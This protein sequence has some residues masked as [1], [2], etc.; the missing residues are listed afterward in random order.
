TLPIRIQLHAGETL[1]ELI[2]RVHRDLLDLRRLEHT[3]L[4]DVARCSGVPAGRALFDSVLVI[5]N[6][7]ELGCDEGKLRFRNFD[8]MD[9]SD[10]ALSI[11]VMPGA[12]SKLLALYDPARFEPAAM[13]RLLDQFAYALEHV[14]D[15]L[16]SP[17]TDLPV[18]PAKE[19]QLLL[20]WGLGPELLGVQQATVLDQI[21]VQVRQNPKQ[22]ALIVE[23]GRLSYGELW[24]RSQRYA[25]A[26]VTR[27][28]RP[29]DRVA[30]VLER[31]GEYV[32]A[33]LGVLRAGACYVPLDPSYPVQRIQAML[34]DCKPAQI[35]AEEPQ[36]QRLGLEQERVLPPAT[37]SLAHSGPEAVPL[38]ELQGQDLAYL[39][40]TSG[41]TG[42]PKAVMVSH[43]NLLAS[44]MAREQFYAE[45][46]DLFLLL[47][48]FAFDSSVAGIYWPLTCGGALLVSPMA[49]EQD[50]LALANLIERYKVSHTLCLPALAELLIELAPA[51]K[52]KS[53]RTLVVA[54]EAVGWQLPERVRNTLPLLRV[55]NEYGPTE[56]TVWCTM[57]D[58]T[59][60]PKGVAPAIG[61][62]IPGAVLRVLDPQ[63]RPVPIGADGELW[64]GG[65]GVAAGYFAQPDISARSFQTLDHSQTRFYRTGDLVRYSEH[66]A[67]LFKGRQDSQI[68]LRGH[69]IELNEIE[70]VL[71]SH[72]AVQEAAALLSPAGQ[73]KPPQLLAFLVPA[74]GIS[75]TDQ[76]ILEHCREQ[77]PRHMVPARIGLCEH[78]PR[79]PNGKVDRKALSLLQP[80]ERPGAGGDRE[81]GTR[82]ERAMAD[83]WQRVLAVE[84]VG[85]DDDFFALGG[86]SLKSI[87]IVALAR[88]RE[89]NLAP[90]EIF[91]YPTIRE[92]AA[93]R[94]HRATTS[95]QPEA[96]VLEHSL[97][98]ATLCLVHGGHRVATQLQ[99]LLGDGRSVRLLSDHRDAG[100]LLPGATV[101]SMAREYL[102]QINAVQTNP[103]SVLAGYS[104]G[105][106]VAFEMARLWQ[107]QGASVPLLLLLDPPDEARYMRSAAGFAGARIKTEAHR[108]DPRQQGNASVG[109][110]RRT[111]RQLLG[112]L[113]S[114]LRLPMP[115]S[116]RH[117]YVGWVYHRA[118]RRYEAT[119]CEG[120][121]AI[122]Y[123]GRGVAR[124]SA[125][126]MLWETLLDAEV[127]SYEF[128]ASHTE[129]VRRPETISA[130]TRHLKALLSDREDKNRK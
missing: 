77:L 103:P 60:A 130:W 110:V 99:E 78:L 44:T 86:D 83:I 1:G 112:A 56:A 89:L 57:A 102:A 119:P 85:L 51:Q 64:V 126:R 36:I 25:E 124:D 65:T 91:E 98:G 118:L 117:S 116:V 104:I 4:G 95:R 30:I 35:I 10:F 49:L 72:E 114:W 52:L 74:A 17:A 100:A 55:C 122:I 14:S 3:P 6:H 26:L 38:P 115:L 42:K 113:C 47:S 97:A 2:E 20:Q 32:L 96:A 121:P 109:R 68:K 94:E 27:Q 105:A 106:P 18:L 63:Q 107:K 53:L 41:S 80:M 54:G 15:G 50:M 16:Q 33:M 120:V 62:P 43:E 70:A 128:Q 28:V 108:N 40:Y 79:L 82:F 67:L 9:Q 13:R 58:I 81:P 39:M 87:R 61:Y 12:S 129:F 123:H 90:S 24:E 66:G 73:G 37:L 48:S 7:P 92:L 127:E 125:G 46:P 88:A 71:R 8:P 22:P 69:R 5:E 11:F 45:A 84:Q 34:Q 111:F 29:G 59:A 21:A 23:T 75:L 31:G 76:M 93:V 101:Q 19:Q